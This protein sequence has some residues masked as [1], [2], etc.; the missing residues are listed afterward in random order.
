ML[1]S[2]L[3]HGS[4]Y[5]MGVK[6]ELD[7]TAILRGVDCGF[8]FGWEQQYWRTIMIRRLKAGKLSLIFAKEKSENEQAAESGDLQVAASGEKA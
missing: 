8:S 4:G 5:I 2:P 1:F 3:L 6:W 7:L